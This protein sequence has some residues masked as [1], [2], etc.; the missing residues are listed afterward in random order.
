MKAADS[1]GRT[2]SRATGSDDVWVPPPPTV[3]ARGAPEDVEEFAVHVDPDD[4]TLLELVSDQKPLVSNVVLPEH[5]VGY[6]EL[7]DV[8][9]DLRDAVLHLPFEA[10]V[11][12][13]EDARQLEV[14]AL[15]RFS[16]TSVSRRAPSTPR[17]AWWSA[18]ALIVG[19][20]RC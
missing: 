4:L 2:L 11:V 19:M 3:P 8:L 20:C 18:H 1:S 12:S 5:G 10:A 9:P 15:V 16:M 14:V 17:C 13:L 7:V 6:D